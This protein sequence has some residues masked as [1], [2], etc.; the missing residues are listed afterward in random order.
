MDGRRWSHP[1]QVSSQ[2]S[3]GDIPWKGFQRDAQCGHHLG[4][5]LLLT[6]SALLPP[7]W[8]QPSEMCSCCSLCP[9]KHISAAFFSLGSKIQQWVQIT[10]TPTASVTTSLQL[11]GMAGGVGLLKV[12]HCAGLYVCKSSQNGLVS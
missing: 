11:Q 6:H 1:A 4:S 8:G 10:P 2:S 12:P 5:I 9:S 3:D 7:L